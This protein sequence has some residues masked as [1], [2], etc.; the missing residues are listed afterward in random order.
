M[1]HRH[2][3]AIDEKPFALIVEKGMFL[4]IFNLLSRGKL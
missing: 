3:G 2:L 4:C 1:K